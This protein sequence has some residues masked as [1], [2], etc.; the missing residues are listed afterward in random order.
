VSNLGEL[1]DNLMRVKG[2]N[3][4]TSTHLA[5]ALKHMLPPI[6]R[7]PNL[8]VV[9]LHRG[10]RHAWHA[11]QQWQVLGDRAAGDEQ[12]QAESRS[13]QPSAGAYTSSVFPHN[14]KYNLFTSIDEVCP[15][16]VW[17]IKS[18]ILDLA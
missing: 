4:L 17:M 2:C 5:E 10:D 13:S 8:V 12:R 16:W 6:H 9:L 18:N 1:V 11:C 15:H 7:R 14:P 3:K